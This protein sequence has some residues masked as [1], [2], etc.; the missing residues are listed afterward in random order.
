MFYDLQVPLGTLTTQKPKETLPSAVK[1]NVEMA[2]FGTFLLSSHTQRKAPTGLL[3]GVDVIAMMTEM[4]NPVP[5][6][7]VASFLY[8]ERTLYSV[9]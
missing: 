5:L 2:I 4:P 1:N 3:A 6:K 9:D 8:L 7:Y